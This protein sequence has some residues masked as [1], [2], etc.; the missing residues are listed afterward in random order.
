MEYKITSYWFFISKP[1][2]DPLREV[3][4]ALYGTQ[5]IEQ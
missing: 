1:S 3:Q 5:S 2:Y 4:Q